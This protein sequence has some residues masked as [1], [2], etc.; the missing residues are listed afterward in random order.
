[1]ESFP[2]KGLPSHTFDLSTK[3]SAELLNECALHGIVV[4]IGE[5]Y[6]CL[7]NKL[8]ALLVQKSYTVQTGTEERKKLLRIALRSLG[9]PIWGLGL[10]NSCA[11]T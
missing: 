3:I 6:D 10:F 9:S 4:P 11:I 5:S 8:K 1:M 2:S 7:L